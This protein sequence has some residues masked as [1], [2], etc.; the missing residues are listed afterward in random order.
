MNNILVL[1]VDEADD[2][3]WGLIVDSP[4]DFLQIVESRINVESGNIS[5]MLAILNKIRSDTFPIVMC[6]SQVDIS[7]DGYE[8]DHRELYEV[9]EVRSYFRRITTEWPIFSIS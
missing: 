8:N 9:P 2:F 3:G 7:I 6:Q 4:F 5:D 1:K